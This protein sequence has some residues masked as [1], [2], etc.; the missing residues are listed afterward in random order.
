MKTAHEELANW[1]N[2]IVSEVEADNSDEAEEE[3]DAHRDRLDA[4]LSILRGRIRMFHAHKTMEAHLTAALDMMYER[5]DA[6]QSRRERFT[7]ACR[8]ARVDRRPADVVDMELRVARREYHVAESDATM[9][10]AVWDRFDQRTIAL[11]DAVE[12]AWACLR[13]VLAEERRAQNPRVLGDA[14]F[15]T[16]EGMRE[17]LLGE[18]KGAN[19]GLLPLDGPVLPVRAPFAGP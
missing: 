3:R 10:Y 6:F 4:T 19:E 9:M 7:R 8:R 16:D 15:R 17:W 14:V 2:G 5:E 18:E 1:A 12:H 11:E 13:G